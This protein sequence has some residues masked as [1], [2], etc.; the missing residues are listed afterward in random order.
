MDVYE[1]FSREELIQRI[2]ELET[3]LSQSAMNNA[4]MEEMSENLANQRKINFLNILMNTILSNVFV[5]ISVK[6]IFDGFKY[7]YFNQ[8]AEDFTEVNASDVLGKTDFELYPDPR[9]AHEIRTED[10]S[11]IKNGRT[12]KIMVE[13]EKPNGDIRIVNTIRLLITNPD[14]GAS[15]LLLVMLWDVTEQ[16]QNE[17]DLIKA[18]EAD[19]MKNAFI[20]NM[21]HEIR[22]PLNAIVG[23]SRLITETDNDSEQ[24]EYLTIIDN[25]SSLL[26]QLI[27]DILDFAKIESG[28]LNYNISYVDLKDICHEVYVSQSLKMTSDVALLYNGDLLPSVRL[29]TDAQRVEQV[30]L[31]LLSNAIKCTN[32]GFISLSYKLE[33][34][35]VRVSVTD[36]GIGIAREKQNAIFDRFVKLD[37]FRQGTGLGLSICK[38]IIEKLGG[39]IGVESEQGKGSCFWF[40]LPLSVPLAFPDEEDDNISDNIPEALPGQYTLLVAEDVLENYLLLQAVLKQQYRLIYAT[41]GRQAVQMFKKYEPDLILMDIKMPVMD[42][43]AATREIRE[44]S[45]DVPVMALS[46]FAYDKE[47]EKAKEYH[48]NDYLVKPVDI[49]LL[50]YKIKYY[51]NKNK[52]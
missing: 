18:R 3:N 52:K 36:T 20:A 27:N 11:T 41:N 34:G 31:N 21:S 9:R 7:I 1:N 37:E 46:A 14:P 13:Y 43:F 24:Q 40:T 38:M 5:A 39:E 47:K 23:F 12:H 44:L 28:T 15:P 29:Q 32:Q 35:F 8:A 48:F 16:R 22:T 26:L 25:N 4:D 49:P 10:Y 42:G 30:L 51:L 19:K 50:K 45:S 2:K 33:D 17:L 6:D